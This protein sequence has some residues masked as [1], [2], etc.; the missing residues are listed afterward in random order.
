MYCNVHYLTQ[1]LDSKCVHIFRKPTLLLCAIDCYVRA[2]NRFAVFVTLFLYYH[3]NWG[4]RCNYIQ[5]EL[6]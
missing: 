1:N 4:G 6:I 3:L 2:F 5:D